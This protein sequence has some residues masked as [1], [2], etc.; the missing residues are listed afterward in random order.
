MT[1]PPSDSPRSPAF[2]TTR[3]TRVCLAKA[4]SEE[5]RRAL[6][7]L[8]EA[9]Y[10]P[11]VAYLRHVLRDSDAALEVSHAFFAMILAGG[12]IASADR[13][14]GRFR[15]YLLGAVKHFVSRQRE[16]HRSLKRGAGGQ[17][18]SLDED[19]IRDI[20]DSRVRSPDAAF[21]RQWALTVLERSLKSLREQCRASGKELLFDQARPFLTGD[22][23]Y[24]DQGAAAAVCGMTVDAFRVAVHR[25][26]RQLRQCLK[27]E[28]AGTV[29]DDRAVIDEMQI[30]FEALGG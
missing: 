21:D 27:S 23:V 9:Y 28:I 11:V 2:H 26:K 30:L 14:R 10:E 4:D 6:A 17:P 22:A 18:V 1:T 20:R 13:E 16:M 24:G 25:L 29:E 19:G 12:H 5:G 7:E 15:S 3:W 8:C